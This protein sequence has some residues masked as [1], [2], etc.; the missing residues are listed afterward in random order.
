MNVNLMTLLNYHIRQYNKKGFT[1]LRKIFTKKDILK[2]LDELNEVKTKVEK[3]N[4]KQYFHKTIDGKFNTI[5]NIQLF[6]K[7]GSIINLT[8][9]KILKTFVK[10]ILNDEPIVRNIEFFLKPKKTGM[11]SPYHQDNYY[12][13]IISAKALNVWIACSKASKINGGICYYEESHNLG[14]INH[15]VSFTK[16]SSQKIPDKIL[17]KLKF[18]KNFPRL[19]V[20]DCLIHHPEV[21]HGS[22]QNKSNNDR[23]G[24]VVSFKSK[25]S[26]VDQVKLK[27]YKNKLKNNLN[28]IYN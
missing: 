10:K 19:N 9:K 4:N 14:T 7:K 25:R 16:G 1:V 3:K 22:N 13:N 8:K 15:V 11:A 18:K 12:W 2:L 5:H 6:H 27:K 28:K 26:R 21:I 20:G 23:I 24:F 17:T